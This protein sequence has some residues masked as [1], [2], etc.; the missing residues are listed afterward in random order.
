M[1]DQQTPDSREYSSPQPNGASQQRVSTSSNVTLALIV[2][3]T[4]VFLVMT[5]KGVSFLFPSAESVLPWG[6]DYG[7]LTLSGQWWRM[8]T[9]LFVHFGFIHILFN[10]IVLFNIGPFIESLAGRVS[11]LILYFV[12]GIGGGVA[13]LIIHPTAVSAGASGAIFGLYGALLGFLLRHRKTI[14][15]KALKSLSKG[16][17]L[18][19]GVN[20]IFGMSVPAI[21]VAAHMGGLAAGFLVALFLVQ[22]TPEENS[23]FTWRGAV[24]IAIGIAMT[25]GAL[26]VIPAP[27]DTLREF[28][29]LDEVEKKAIDLYNDS[30]KKWKAHQISDSQFADIVEQQILP[31]WSAER[32]AIA[33]LRHLPRAQAKLTVSLLK[34]MDIRRDA[35]NLLVEGL[36]TNNADKIKQSFDRN[37]EADRLAKTIGNA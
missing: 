25:V 23:R 8:F 6:A 3:N 31:K 30:E 20:F 7:P 18:F 22:R 19:V 32:E 36:R 15:P 1:D 34:Y 26:R 12:S 29:R 10:M 16:A 35:W 21:G 5:L 27:S 4:L 33:N 13:S 17:L 9:S 37:S 28:S 11:Y 24:A 14:A 2:L